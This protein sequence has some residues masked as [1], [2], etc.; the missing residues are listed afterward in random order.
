MD[1]MFGFV[2]VIQIRNQFKELNFV[3][4]VD[5]VQEFSVVILSDFFLQLLRS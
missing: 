5:K 2:F 1:A 3:Y 4:K